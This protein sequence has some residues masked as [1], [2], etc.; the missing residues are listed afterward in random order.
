MPSVEIT[1]APG[2]TAA[3]GA[4]IDCIARARQLA[5]LI[6]AQAARSERDREIASEVL[7]ALHEAAEQAG[8]DPAGITKAGFITCLIGDE[9]EIAEMIRQPLVKA[10]L[11]YRTYHGSAMSP[12][13][14]TAS[15]AVAHSLGYDDRQTITLDAMVDV[16][17]R[18]AQAV[19]VPLTAD[20]EWG[21]A[22]QPEDVA[23]RCSTA[24][25]A[26]STRER[27]LSLD[28]MWRTCSLTVS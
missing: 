25:S 16:V 6:A 10:F 3:A 11:L 1:S 17:G 13:V 27:R 14:A 2:G 20:T 12:A 28:R 18:V 21:Y 7:A 5:P 24:N 23:A 9:G 8:R 4:A 19:R 22:E 26:A 15:W